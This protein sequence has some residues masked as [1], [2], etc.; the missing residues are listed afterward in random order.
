[1]TSEEKKR[2][3]QAITDLLGLVV[4]SGAPKDAVQ[5]IAGTFE[6]LHSDLLTELVSN[7]KSRTIGFAKTEVD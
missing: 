2:V 4:E 7:N 5:F 6:A 1:M 3:G